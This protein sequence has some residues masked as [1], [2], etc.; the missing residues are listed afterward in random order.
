MLKIKT[1]LAIHVNYTFTVLAQNNAIRSTCSFVT[2]ELLESGLNAYGR[3]D[4]YDMV[5]FGVSSEDNRSD[6]TGCIQPVIQYRFDTVIPTNEYEV[7]TVNKRIILHSDYSFVIE[8]FPKPKAGILTLWEFGIKGLSRVFLQDPFQSLNGIKIRPN[9]KV[10]VDIEF[11]HGY[12]TNNLTSSLGETV[13]GQRVDYTTEVVR[14][15]EVGQAAIRNTAGYNIGE[16]LQIYPIFEDIRGKTASEIIYPVTYQYQ[17]HVT[18]CDEFEHRIDRKVIG[19]CPEASTIYGFILKD[20][21]RDV[22][23]LARFIQ[24]VF[25]EKEKRFEVGGYIKWNKTYDDV[26]DGFVTVDLGNYTEGFDIGTDIE[27]FN[28]VR[29]P[30]IPEAVS[31]IKSLSAISFLY[32]PNKELFPV[33]ANPDIQD[34]YAVLNDMEIKGVLLSNR[35]RAHAP[36]T[37]DLYTPELQTNN[38]LLQIVRSANQS[39]E[40]EPVIIVAGNYVDSTPGQNSWRWDLYYPYIGRSTRQVVYSWV[41][42]EKAKSTLIDVS[43][44]DDQT[45]SVENYPGSPVVSSSA[46]QLLND[47]VLSSRGLAH[48]TLE[49]EQ[50]DWAGV[51][52][53]AKVVVYQNDFDGPGF[54]DWVDGQTTVEINRRF[55]DCVTTDP[56]DDATN[57]IDFSVIFDSRLHTP[58]NTKMYIANQSGL[59]V[60]RMTP[61]E[62]DTAIPSIA[63][64]FGI[65]IVKTV[66]D[67][68]TTYRF[69]R[70]YT[71]EYTEYQ[72]IYFS[73]TGDIPFGPSECGYMQINSGSTGYRVYN[74][75]GSEVTDILRL[76]DNPFLCFGVRLYQPRPDYIYKYRILTTTQAAAFFNDPTITKSLNTNIFNIGFQNTTYSVQYQN[77]LDWKDPLLEGAKLYPAIGIDLTKIDDIVDADEVLIVDPEGLSWTKA[78]LLATRTTHPTRV[79]ADTFYFA[80]P[81]QLIAGNQII[82]K[83]INS[84]FYQQEINLGVNVEVLL[85]YALESATISPNP[86]TIM[87]GE[88]MNATYSHYPPQAVIT[89]AE[90]STLDP[91]IATVNASTGAVTGI[92]PGTTTLRLLLNNTIIATATVNVIDA[93]IVISCAD[94]PNITTCLTMTGT[95]FE[96]SVNDAEIDPSITADE[97]RTYFRD[98]DSYRIVNCNNFTNP[99]NATV[100]ETGFMDLTGQFDVYYNGTLVGKD[101]NGSEVF[102]Q[103]DGFDGIIIVQDTE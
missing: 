36:S 78:Q 9:D 30:I 8:G 15:N 86:M 11:T 68:R 79:I 10:R 25:I 13:F 94:A 28:V 4:V 38:A 26:N 75:V 102:N 59:S 48:Y 95:D 101:I 12:Y 67:T 82:A 33:P 29:P 57:T 24:P 66:V 80:Y 44:I 2:N 49:F 43:N 31:E 100:S 84:T 97:V 14:L 17:Q 96:L 63:E 18:K 19:Y 72:D 98:N 83:Q 53:P 22:G 23:V 74:R 51:N 7:D 34:V 99:A 89:S 1:G 71:T 41:G 50:M 62:L 85:S 32:G 91:F 54:V 64:T 87:V 93:N 69:T 77:T 16:P 70:P 6:L 35:P 20:K 61:T 45:V 90:W 42:F 76:V 21:L 92:V 55:L 58:A 56:A 40:F 88:T 46:T 5:E 81:V 47:A 37:F 39:Y 27:D 60:Y 3:A 103:L 73:G 52:P 65:R